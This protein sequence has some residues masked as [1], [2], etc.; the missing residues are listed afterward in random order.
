MHWLLYSSRRQG[1]CL[2]AFLLGCEKVRVEMPS[3]TVLED[4]SLGV[5]AGQRIGIEG[6]DGDGE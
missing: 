4:V 6:R 5:D 3:K 1:G 2:V